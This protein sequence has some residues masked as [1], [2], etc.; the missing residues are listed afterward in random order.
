[1]IWASM[2][3]RFRV[4]LL[5]ADDALTLNERERDRLSR[6]F[7]WAVVAS[8]GSILEQYLTPARVEAIA[9]NYENR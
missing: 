2:K 8:D 5:N 1:M 9:D 3:P 7:R 6:G 4:R